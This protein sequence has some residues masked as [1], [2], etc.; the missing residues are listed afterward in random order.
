[1]RFVLCVD[2]FDEISYRDREWTEVRT[3][4]NGGTA[5][6]SYFG[7]PLCTCMI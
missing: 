3:P 7:S 4:Y 5:V 1:M 2:D 6:T